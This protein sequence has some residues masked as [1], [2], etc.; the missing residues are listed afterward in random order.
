MAD[1]VDR[2]LFGSKPTQNPV[3]PSEVLLRLAES[4]PAIHVPTGLDALDALT[5][6]GPRLGDVVFLLGA[7]DAGKTAFMIQLADVLSRD[8]KVGVYCIDE[9]DEGVVS[10][11][12]Q[13]RGW[14]R[15]D[16]EARENFV[17]LAS[18][19]PPL[20]IYDGG[21]SL[22]KV[23][24][25]MHERGGQILCVDSLQTL[26]M[27]VDEKVSRTESIS[28]AI[29]TLR[30]VARV[31]RWLVIVTS[32]M[33]RGSY[34]GTGDRTAA[35]AAGKWSGDIE[36]AAKVLLALRSVEG[37]DGV[38]H[39][40][41]AKN[42]LGPHG[43]FHLALDRAS[44][45]LTVCEAPE[46][47]PAGQ[48]VSRAER[49]AEKVRSTV[50]AKQARAD[51]ARAQAES[52]FERAREVMLAHPKASKRELIALIKGVCLCGNERAHTALV[53]LTVPRIGPSDG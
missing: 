29:T 13:R 2:L 42:K 31:N 24:K 49:A 6:G 33:V 53:K 39:V 4:G 14:Q 46:I 11:L 8:Y 21:W 20:L 1:V 36:Y 28:A 18:A 12:G 10:R 19:M 30:D 9:D 15:R 52:D 22:E 23:C 45:H 41:C 37:G 27:A 43:E 50:A 38:I 26:K 34:S 51:A 32:E 48:S 16:I 35:L 40:E 5:G 7:P 25:D 3:I 47:K 44:Q 17:E